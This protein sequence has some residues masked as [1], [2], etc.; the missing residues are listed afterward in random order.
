[1]ISIVPILIIPLSLLGNGEEVVKQAPNIQTPMYEYYTRR[2]P[3]LEEA[4]EELRY[5]EH[6]KELEQQIQRDLRLIEEKKQEELRR[7]QEELR[8][9]QEKER[10]EKMVRTYY[11]SS[12][13]SQPSLLTAEELNIAIEGTGL[14]GLGQY[15]YEAEQAYGVNSVFL[16]SIAI[17][18]SGWGNST[19]AQTKNNLFGYQAYDNDPNKAMYF[20]SKAE[21]I[22]TVGSHL[23]KNYLRS[24]GK[25]YNGATP[26]G[27]NVMYC[28]SGEWASKVVSIMNKVMDSVPY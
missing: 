4:Q 14:Q 12:D 11:T 22:D 20:S 8:Q 16:L 25:Y 13:V 6:L 2:M 9:A 5:Q 28:S 17:L 10:K 15:F 7:E 18:E 23:A 26:A 21:A 24:D 3:D 27:V 1:M 19:L